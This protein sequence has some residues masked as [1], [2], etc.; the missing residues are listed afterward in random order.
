MVELVP[1]DCI[2]RWR[3]ILGLFG[4]FIS[5]PAPIIGGI[6]WENLGLSC[7]ILIPITRASMEVICR[8]TRLI[9]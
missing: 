9:Y 3:G 2:G 1:I 5:I 4:G 7:L 8:T 6:F